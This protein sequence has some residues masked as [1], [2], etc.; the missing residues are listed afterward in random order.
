MR[1]LSPAQRYWPPR[2]APP[3][4]AVVLARRGVRHGAVLDSERPRPHDLRSREL[5]VEV[6]RRWDCAQPIHLPGALRGDLAR[7]RA[8]VRSTLDLFQRL[9]GGASFQDAV[10]SRLSR[11]RR[12]EPAGVTMDL[13]D[14]REIE[15]VFA[16]ARGRG[17]ILARDLYAKLSWISHDER[18]LSLRIRFSFGSEHLLDWQKESRRAPWADRLAEALFP[19]SSVLG[20]NARLAAL[21]EFARGRRLRCSE[22][23]VYSNAPGGGALFHHDVEPFQVGVLYGQLAG[24]TAWLA[25]PKREL[26]AE[27]ASFVGGSWL[28]TARTALDWL[29]R[30]DDARLARLLNHTPRFTRRLVARGSFLR[31]RAGDA[32]LLPSPRPD[33]ACWHSVFALGRRPSLAHSYGLFDRRRRGR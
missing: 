30:E 7:K 18:D 14:R 6:R 9:R 21:L 29:E 32:L 1:P 3:R 27:V 26:A 20:Q 11:D 33:D 13:G 25:L 10:W 15:K 5:R 16:H 12:F 28:R 23:I 8:E 22:R 31:L 19:E 17:R 2:E 24:E 4:G